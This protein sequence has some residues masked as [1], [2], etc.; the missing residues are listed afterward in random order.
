MC[1]TTLI[2]KAKQGHS[3][4]SKSPKD[5]KV[6]FNY[7]EWINDEPNDFGQHSS[8]LLSSHKDKKDEEGK[9]YVGNGKKFVNKPVTSSDLPQDSW[10]DNIPVKEKKPVPDA[11]EITKPIDDLPF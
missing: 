6:Y 4:F 2:E 3:A 9:V 7:A 5:N 8:I 1:L 11:A 10:D